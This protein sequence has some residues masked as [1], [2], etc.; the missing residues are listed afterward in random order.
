MVHGFLCHPVA[1]RLK[2][3]RRWEGDLSPMFN[4]RY[5]DTPRRTLPWFDYFMPLTTCLDGMEVWRIR[6]CMWLERLA[7]RKVIEERALPPWKVIRR[8]ISWSG[9]CTG[10]SSQRVATSKHRRL[11]ERGSVNRIL[12]SARGKPRLVLSLIVGPL[13]LSARRLLSC[14]HTAPDSCSGCGKGRKFSLA[15]DD[16]CSSGPTPKTSAAS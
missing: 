14:V 7:R 4:G 11:M 6:R 2:R 1:E 9:S 8:N 16:K 13:F 10:C 12:R 15:P 3:Q 5:R